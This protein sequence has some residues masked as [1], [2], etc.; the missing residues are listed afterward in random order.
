LNNPVK[1]GFSA[2]D[3][4]MRSDVILHHQTNNTNL[5]NK[6]MKT[7]KILSAL[8]LVLIFAANSVYANLIND[9]GSQTMQKMVTYVVKVNFAPNFPG[10]TGHYLV[11][12]T[13]EHGRK[14]V[15]AQ[16]F[17]PGL[18]SYT[19]KEAGSFR[20]TRIAVMVP[21]PASQAG[22]VIPPCV[23]KATFIGGA[24]YQFNLAPVSNEK[25]DPKGN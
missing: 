20:G 12:I 19:F 5:K 9:P 14:V 6:A 10:A 21:Y 8:S 4:A 13:D 16:P 7:T 1:S 23:L 18:W 25:T 3:P 22:W 17:H 11:A 2:L 15:P 24:T